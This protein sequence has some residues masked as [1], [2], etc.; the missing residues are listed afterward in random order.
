MKTLL[1]ILFF[2]PA[3]FAQEKF[4]LTNASKT[5]DVRITVENC[6]NNSCEGKLKVELFTKTTHEPFQ[7]FNLDATAFSV[8]EAESVNTKMLYDS[9]S[10]V[11]LEDYNFDGTPDL[12]IRDGNNGG[13]G[14]PSYQIYL[15]SPRTKKFV[16]NS[17]LTHLNQDGYLG[18]MEVDKKKKVLRTFSKDGCCWHQTEEFA[19]VNNRSKKVFEETEDATAAVGAKVKITTK[20]FVKGR[21]RTSVKYVKR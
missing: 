11:F 12:A 21:W 6:E 3:I 1:L 4:E 5:Y 17:A 8:E 15:F 19:V 10:V 7:T 20:K 18:A 14:G 13:Y 16:H 2:C 9:Q